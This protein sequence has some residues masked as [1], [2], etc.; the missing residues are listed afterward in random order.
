MWECP[1]LV[2]MRKFVQFVSR[3][4]TRHK[5][6]EAQSEPMAAEQVRPVASDCRVGWTVSSLHI[7]HGITI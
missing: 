6:A 4:A 3:L 2:I 1:Y 5:D 7:W